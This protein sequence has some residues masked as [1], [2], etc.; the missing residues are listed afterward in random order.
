MFS[1]Q[2]TVW[3]VLSTPLVY[4]K[5]AGYAIWQNHNKQSLFSQNFVQLFI[6]IYIIGHHPHAL[7]SNVFSMI[8]NQ[9]KLTTKSCENWGLTTTGCRGIIYWEAITYRTL[10]HSKVSLDTPSG[11]AVSKVGI[12]HTQGGHTR[13]KYEIEN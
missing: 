2:G 11:Y 10:H 12:W 8:F 7:K 6:P 5:V 3:A 9:A 4:H 1:C 13:E